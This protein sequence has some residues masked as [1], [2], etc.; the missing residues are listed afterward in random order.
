MSKYP[1]IIE[2]IIALNPLPELSP[3]HGPSQEVRHLLQGIKLDELFPSPIVSH[4]AAYA[5][6]AGLWLRVDGLEECH[7]I[8]QQEPGEILSALNLHS[9]A[10]KPLQNMGS[11]QLVENDKARESQ[12][13]REMTTTFAYWHGIMHRRE[14]DYG[15]AK[16]WFHRVGQHPVHDELMAVARE[17][18]G[19]MQADA[20]TAVNAAHDPRAIY[21]AAGTTWDADRFVDFCEATA[22]GRSRVPSATLATE[23]HYDAVESFCRQMQRRECEILL[24]FCWQR[25]IG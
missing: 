14:P 22:H 13:L 16:Y 18:A 25:A 23:N 3:P 9:K 11:V 4:T 1:P 12:H 2:Q 24:K 19:A 15:N 5:C 20:P 10:S 8:V 17:L 6:L 21:L 7:Q